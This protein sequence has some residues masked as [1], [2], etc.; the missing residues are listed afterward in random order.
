MQPVAGRTQEIS[1]E[2]YY[3]PLNYRLMK[4]LQLLVNLVERWHGVALKLGWLIIKQL[5]SQSEELSEMYIYT[6]VHC[7]N[8]I[9]SSVNL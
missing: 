6:M 7:P 1:S 9:L 2:L 3:Y 8:K 4:K 5:I